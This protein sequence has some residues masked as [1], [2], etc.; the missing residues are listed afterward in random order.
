MNTNPVVERR[1]PM[2]REFIILSSKYPHHYRLVSNAA[3]DEQAQELRVKIPK[4]I[5]AYYKANLRLV[6]PAG[7]SDAV[8]EER[9]HQVLACLYGM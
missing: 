1:F 9:L 4:S 3:A 6:L 2:L 5:I 7:T 8:A